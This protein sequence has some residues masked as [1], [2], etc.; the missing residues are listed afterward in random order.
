MKRIFY[1][2][3]LLML[4]ATGTHAQKICCPQFELQQDYM[5][6]TEKPFHYPAPVAPVPPGNGDTIPKDNC[7]LAACKHTTHTYTVLPLKT[8]YTYT[9]QIIGGTAA[10]VTGN[11]MKVTWSNG[12]EGLIKV[13]ISNADGTCR[14][15]ITVALCLK[16]APVAGF[17]FSPTS[18]VCLNQSLQ[19][20]NS[21]IGATSY[22][23]DFGDGS[24]STQT[25]P[26]H[27]YTT[28]GTYTIV[29]AVLSGD[30]GPVRPEQGTSC[31]CRDTIRK[32]I[33][34]KNESGI[35]IISGCKKML[36]KGDTATYCTS[37]QCNGY[38]WSV[39]G[40]RI[41]G[42]A[43]GT[44]ITVVWDGNYPA[45]VT[46]SG[47]CGGSCGN[48]G[49]LNVPVLFP[50]MPIQGNAIVC[51]S[52]FSSYSLPSM[53]GTFYTWQISGGGTIVGF[54]T[55]TSV[56]NVQWNSIPGTYTITCNYNNPVTGCSGTA[57]INVNVL[58]PF[59]INGKTKYCVGSGFNYST[60]V[61]NAN[62]TIS[63][64]TGHTPSTFA[65][66]TTITGTWNT[67]GNYTITATPTSP[68]SY[69]SYPAIINVV[70]LDVPR[71]NAITGP[72]TICPGGI[73]VFGIS[74][75]MNDGLY[76]W[77]ITG[78]SVISN[79]GSHHD[80]VMVQWDPS[81]PYEITVHQEVNGCSSPDKTLT[82]NIYPKPEI[83]GQTTTCMD[84]TLTYTATGAAPVGGYNW[85][86]QNAL[87]TIISGQG[88]NTVTI[89]WHG[90]LPPASPDCILTVHTCGGTGTLKV[91]VNAAAPVIINKTGTL[92][93]TSGITLTA[94]ISGA[95]NYAWK[96]N[97]VSTG[98]NTQSINITT[99]G[100]YTVTI[101]QANGCKS[102]GSILI[103]E[104][105]LS[106]SA[107]LSTIDKTTW[108]CNETISTTLHAIPSAPGYCYKWF[109]KAAGSGGPGTLIS[110][111]TTANYTVNSIGL[112][113][114]EIS[115]CNT[116]C[117]AYT[118]TINII[119]YGC[120]QSGSCNN[121]YSINVITTGCN[122]FTFTGSTSP[123]A[124]SGSVY[125]YFGDGDEGGGYSV[126]HR[127]R[128][129]G[130][131]KVC[132]IFG[133]SPYCIRDTCFIIKVT[134]AAK[135]T[136]A[137]NCDSVRFNNLS[138]SA[139]TITS[140]AWQFPGGLPAVGS[141]VTPPPIYYA[142]GGL[143]TAILT[144][145]DGQCIVS[146]TIS[147]T[148]Y[149]VSATMNVP[150][151]I[152]A[153]TNAA[154]TA[155]SSNPDLTYHWNFGDSH[156]SNQ[157][158]TT[159]AYDLA[160]A[161]IVSLTV[162][163]KNGCSRIDTMHITVLAEITAAI[164]ADK[165][166]CPGSTVTLTVTPSFATYQW[167][168]DGVAIPAATIATYTTGDIGEYWVAVANGNGC[169]AISNHS[170]VIYNDLPVI[171][172]VAPTIYCSNSSLY[173]H[174]I[175]NDVNCNYSWTA[176]GPAAVL[177]SAPNS[178][179]TMVTINSNTVGEYQII[180]TAENKT[181][182]CKVKD[183]V[184]ITLVLSPH[185]TVTAPAG[186]LC[187]GKIYTFTATATPNISP[188]NYIYNW[189]NGA[190]GS[191]ISTGVP[192]MYSVTVTNP[193]GCKA[194]A[195]AGTINQRPDVSLFP[196]GCDT[197][198]LTD[199]LRFPLPMPLPFGGSYTITWYDDD[200]TA[201]ANVGSG[202]ILPL[203][204]LQPGIHH[205]YAIVSLPGGGCAD[206]TG[207]F[208]LYVKD[209]TL[210]P[211][212][213]NCTGLLQSASATT[214]ANITS[215][216]TYQLINGTL[217]FTILK[218]VKEVRI[219]L[220]DLA[221]YWKD[222][223]CNN[224]KL[225][226]IERGC[227]FPAAGGNNL[228]TLVW[229]DY[230]TSNIPPA[231]S[232]NKCPDELVW[233]NGTPLQPGTYTVPLQISLPRSSKEKCVLVIEKLCFHLTVIDTGCNRC[234]R[235]VC[236]KDNTGGGDGGDKDCKCNAANTWTSLYM[237][238]K[239]PGI[240][241][242][243]NLIICNTTL[244]DI[245]SNTP[246][247]LSGI[248][249]CQGKCASTKNE[250]TVYDQVNQIIYTHVAAALNETIVFPAPGM[251]SISL[252]ATCGTQK[253]TCAFRIF[254]DGKCVDCTVVT[255]GGGGSTIPHGNPFPID[256]VLQGILPP[257]FNGGILVSKN[258]SVLYEK[259]ISYKDSVNSHTSFDL[260]SVTKTFTSMAILKLMEDGKLNL[261][262]AV[263]KYL[264]E[265]P[266]PEI[267]IKMLL[268]HRSGLEDYLKFI[269]ES[270]WDKTKNLTN[271]GLLQF[272]SRNKAKVLINT[273]G[274]V[275][276]YSNTNFALLSLIIEKVSG[277]LYKD[278]L[279]VT[280]FRPL[281]MND[282]YVLGIDN[283]V[284]ATKSY[285][286]NGDAYTS[287]YLDYVTGDKCVFST[288]QDL[289]KW[290]K[291]LRGGKLFKRSTLDLAYV[292][293]NPLAPFTS[294]YGLGWK[295]IVTSNGSEMIYHTGWWAGS[296]SILIRLPKEN[297]MI[298]VL[299]NNNFTNIADIRKL[300]DLFGDYQQSGRKIANF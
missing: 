201:I 296:R 88:T 133:T 170:H 174:N 245:V 75:N 38:N 149:S 127:Y 173:A 236:K 65:A 252:S 220:A 250:I 269:D 238:P 182:H 7:E 56:I 256:S 33:T 294:N 21:S 139:A 126:I 54:N 150:T 87:G 207:L 230:T 59:T 267:T 92:C 235:M 183:T 151:P 102:T 285:K 6:C 232:I 83:T 141:W 200:G 100:T 292:P 259:Y 210:L 147:F 91:T 208:E 211:A 81:G 152:C 50:T 154:F 51:P 257:D 224:C 39:T 77:N 15:T 98:G 43:N 244:T 111:A 255:P 112:Y 264:P 158:N 291:G 28:P 239:K 45:T 130:S 212:C 277:Q 20:S 178:Y 12:N 1:I 22:Y 227:L 27:I 107:S 55:N 272:I 17:T 248:F 228:G 113:W 109:T 278:Y 10:T 8:G 62:W 71:L 273:P 216:A 58:P 69:C 140:Y 37:N 80:S 166:I 263:V 275:F 72:A 132:A 103:P 19:F 290:D 288:V 215:A 93:S 79:M 14:D 9:W 184:C 4:M 176:T 18:P 138:K 85:T 180:L 222:T 116:S 168:K 31:G 221:Y 118:D 266:I 101:T 218:P 159:H 86:L 209:C 185:V 47:S 34:V 219:S 203:S 40:G 297:V 249:H 134:I 165:Y 96:L 156:V 97:N 136:A 3:T 32:T 271:Q 258:D 175:F 41:L 25:N 89:L 99:T 60:A 163:D 247:V 261:D 179:G 95:S 48:S 148:T 66:G 233:K 274:K 280:F 181:T 119:K 281:Q 137:V 74:S 145:S 276:D 260:A 94:S 206:T 104:E 251:Y 279:S 52:S 108:N 114:C 223:T 123:V 153:K 11:P 246:Y 24:S 110:T 194:Y 299:S 229:D 49:T 254:V 198:C 84:N 197:L 67:P 242:P 241:K 68:S 193:S 213:D 16:D 157:Q 64:S 46:M 135:I 225:Q 143:H 300:C 30:T 188:D 214:N 282:T 240:P 205:L 234:D 298:A 13:F 44:C 293:A 63:P 121:D 287:R 196:V 106:V 155:T 217:T 164:G 42:S 171:K 283:F 26:A 262:D 167:Y 253:C 162:T 115:L 78:G 125:W 199:T 146:D 36:C 160:G 76:S 120:G 189:S 70:V 57:N 53:P 237:L 73:N 82:L 61:G 270:D 231:T 5:P 204:N 142:A 191:T 124:A 105:K 169:M 2:L 90:A 131:Y 284:K 295:K 187:E 35:N 289:R 202:L 23:W 192:G 190:T 129:T 177:F 286:K 117:K 243:T 172:I 226:M 29:L 186:P 144:V 128:D 265:F 195:F 122:P 268:S 161:Y